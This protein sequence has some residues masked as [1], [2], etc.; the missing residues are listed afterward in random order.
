MVVCN[1]IGQ[2]L[3]IRNDELGFERPLQEIR[4]ARSS[5]GIALSS[6]APFQRFLFDTAC[7]QASVLEREAETQLPIAI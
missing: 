5:L 7:A 6:K 1:F 2:T 3:L 4:M